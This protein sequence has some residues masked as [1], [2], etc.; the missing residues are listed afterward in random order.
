MPAHAHVDKNVTD[1]TRIHGS[2]MVI[3]AGGCGAV[4]RY[5]VLFST[6]PFVFH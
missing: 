3:I 4:L 2:E 1:Q 6:C 5:L